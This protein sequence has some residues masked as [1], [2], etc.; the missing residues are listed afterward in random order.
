MKIQN[1]LLNWMDS[2]LTQPRY[3]Y[4]RFG[5]RRLAFS[6]SVVG[7]GSVQSGGLRK[8]GSSLWNRV[9]ICCSTL[10]LT[11]S[12]LAVAILRFVCFST[13]AGV[14]NESIVS[15][16]LENPGIAIGTACLS[17]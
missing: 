15:S 1:S 14:D 3:N 5:D 8:P 10:D 6:V 2:V 17:F 9:F 12:G 11:T 16:D 13:S 7:E 4:F